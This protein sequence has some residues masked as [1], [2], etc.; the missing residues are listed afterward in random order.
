MV[1]CCLSLLNS[2]FVFSSALDTLHFSFFVVFR[3]ILI[4]CLINKIIDKSL[5][6]D[7][8]LGSNIFA[9]DKLGIRKNSMMSGPAAPLV[10]STCSLREWLL[11]LPGIT[12]LNMCE[13]KQAKLLSRADSQ[14][15][16]E[17][18]SC[19]VHVFHCSCLCSMKIAVLGNGNIKFDMI[20]RQRQRG[21]RGTCSSLISSSYFAAMLLITCLHIGAC[22]TCIYTWWS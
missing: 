9:W 15:C 8:Q 17:L 10:F 1:L 18:V 16:S 14:L 13:C 7:L 6:N 5:L 2:L 3:E 11:S 22:S 20:R 19:F 4:Q 12:P 21:R